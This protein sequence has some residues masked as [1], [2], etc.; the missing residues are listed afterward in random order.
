LGHS[1][2]FIIKKFKREF[3]YNLQLVLASGSAGLLSGALLMA[4]LVENKDD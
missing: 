4:A 2:Y 3:E 1:A